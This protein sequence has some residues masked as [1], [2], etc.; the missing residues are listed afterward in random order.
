MNHKRID[1][2][3]SNKIKR[4][5]TSK[6]QKNKQAAVWGKIHKTYLIQNLHLDM[7]YIK[8]SYKSIVRI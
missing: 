6:E 2:I 3:D 4:Y 7:R 8:N 1:A 5:C